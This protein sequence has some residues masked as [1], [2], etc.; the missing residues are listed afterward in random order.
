MTFGTLIPLI[1]LIG[2]P[3]IIIIYL[4]KPKGTPIVIPSLLLWKNAERNEKS[5]TFSRKLI[6]NILM[7][8]E[9]AALLFLM[10]AA[11][12]PAIKRGGA[13]KEKA[14]LIIIDTSGSMQFKTGENETRFDQAIKDAKD[15]V[16]MSSGYVSVITSASEN[17]LII[18]S[19]K[20]KSKLKKLLTSVKCTDTIC[21]LTETE[22]LIQSISVDKV[23]VFTDGEGASKLEE[24][25]QRYPMD[26]YVYGTETDN[27]SIS[28]MSM[29]QTDDGLY[30]ISVTYAYYGKHKTAFDISVYDEKN[31]LLDVRTIELEESGSGSILLTDKKVSG[32]YVRGEVSQVSFNV[33]GE[34]SYIDGLDADNTAYAVISQ[35]AEYDAYLV[36]VGN[37][38][39][40]KAYQAATGDNLIKVTSEA[41]I[42]DNKKLVAVYDDSRLALGSYSRILLN[43]TGDSDKELEGGVV[44][45][46]SQGLLGSISD[47]SFGASNLKKLNTPEW[48]VPFMT[49]NEGT[50]E[51]A[52][53]GY[54]GEHDGIREIV[55]GF[56]VRDSEFPLMA[57]FPIFIADAMNYLADESV[58]ADTYIYAGNVPKTRPAEDIDKS[59]YESFDYAGIYSLADE[60][61]VVR[62]PSVESD[63]TILEESFASAADGGFGISYSSLRRFCLIIA[64][65]L[66]IL[67]LIIYALRNRFYEKLPL[68]VRICLILFVI[69]AIA[70]IS[71]PGKK[72]GCATIFL[73]DMSDSSRQSLPEME[74]YLKETIA[75][76]PDGDSFG[77]VTFGRD[78]IT[79]QF[80]VS[81]AQY[82]GIASEPNK[83][84]TDIEGA[85]RYA[86]ALVP[87]DKY[88]RIVLLSDGK[89]TVGDVAETLSLLEKD[90]IELCFKSFES[91]EAQDVYIQ[92]ADMPRIL[93]T[94]DEYKLK[95]TVFSTFET[96]A[97]LK[98]T[99][100]SELRSETQVHLT[101]GENTFVINDTAGD[102]SIEKRLVTIEAA[103]DEVT[104][105]NSVVAAATV[106]APKRILLISGLREDSAGF[107]NLLNSLNVNLKTVSA[108][109]APDSLAEMLEYKVI[110]LD[111][112]HIDDLPKGF[113]ENLQSYVKDYGGGLITTGGKESY[114]PGGYKDTALEKILPVDCLPK[115]YNEAPA[116]A[117]VMIIDCSGSMSSSDSSGRSKIDV[118]VDAAKEAVDA[119]NRDDQVGVLT[120]SDNYN[121]RQPIVH[122]SDKD[123]VNKA[124]EGIGIQGGTVIKPAVIEAANSLKG[125]DSGVKHILLLTDGEGE[126]TNFEDAI[127]LIN[128]NNIT[129]STIAV[130][131]DSDTRLLENL[132]DECGGRYYYS[133]ESTDIPKIFTEEVYLS[134][135][136]YFKS[137][138]FTLS[139]NG[140]SKLIEGLYQDGLPHI[141][142]YIATSTKTGAREVISTDEDDPLLSSWQYGLG[143]AISWMSNASGSWDESLIRMDD[144]AAMWRRMIDMAS[145]EGDAGND[146]LTFNKRRGVL[147]IDYQAAEYSENSK[148]TGVYTTPSGETKEISLIS[149]NPG[150]YSA[151]V[152]ADEMGVYSINIHRTEGDEMKASSTAV[153]AVQ[154]SD[155][156][157]RDI[158]NENLVNFI[159]QSGRILEKD[160]YVFTRLKGKQS[161]RK[162]ITFLLIVCSIILLIIDIVFRRFAVAA[163]VRSLVEKLGIKRTADTKKSGTKTAGTKTAVS[164]KEKM[165]TDLN[166][167]I[168][169]D[170][171]DDS[172]K[173]IIGNISDTADSENK[174]GR[175]INKKQKKKNKKNEEETV[176]DTLDTAALLKKK[177]DRNL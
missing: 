66:I 32:S 92:A 103:G 28:Q 65:L 118:A 68:I 129:L 60:H 134:G 26:I 51:E 162:N 144:Y 7:F 91:I 127:E 57:E 82:L 44:Y 13:P 97:V 135:D 117:M 152:P 14:S 17:K 43:Y 96:D 30:D 9:I 167:Q 87:D 130:G 109:N 21:S 6:R 61:L 126:T 34:T 5:M 50:E 110:I 1:F 140:S 106:D 77:I 70:G 12:S 149:D 56:D 147:Q 159:K 39:V 125:V 132:A 122:L 74:K 45:V 151:S 79:D 58:L 166:N 78:A 67:D 52:T 124:I 114:A 133:D 36:G 150:E 98:V 73:V 81:D 75:G 63:G 123:A 94:G 119:M 83:D 104:E 35:K 86:S 148:V 100:E 141:N 54:F 89:E 116:L 145:M 177:K 22:G 71:L 172:D 53:V 88:A 90:E 176:P 3:I 20:D 10:L 111:N 170:V 102:Q 169:D 4:M 121:W 143:T 146:T 42:E 85:V 24:M 62:Y 48:A 29:K 113:D 142:G 168:I 55:L 2:I 33:D 40:E 15:L 69:L 8:I 107:E 37:V 27:V 18:N 47:F 120:F 163:K 31:N 158:S 19:S 25:S 99:E 136:T 138:D 23:Y 95:V 173:D 154:F 84:A 165:K 112:C 76:M 41:D 93:S 164:K 49:V 108:V 157:R 105:N 171:I 131:S 128:D 115:G 64:L 80:V 160:D 46:S 155:E 139:Q 137:G 38:F 153:M 101:P 174:T 72:R 156:Y 175:T 16:E 161:N 11:M 59:F